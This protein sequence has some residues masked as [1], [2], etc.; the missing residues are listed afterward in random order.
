[1]NEEKLPHERF[2]EVLRQLDELTDELYDET[3]KH[4]VKFLVSREIREELTALT[5]EY[6]DEFVTIL[7][8]D[9]ITIGLRKFKNRD[10]Q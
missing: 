5:Q 2:L 4:E 8:N 10:K 9:F 3:L 6:G 7:V 1:M